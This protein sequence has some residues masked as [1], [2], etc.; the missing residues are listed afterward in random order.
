MCRPSGREKISVST[1]VC[2]G[3]KYPIRVDPAAVSSELLFAGGG[4]CFSGREDSRT[5]KEE[6]VGG[7]MASIVLS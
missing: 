2:I 1:L 4:E 3:E 5:G 6:P 7:R